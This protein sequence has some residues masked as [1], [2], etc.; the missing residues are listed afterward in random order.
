[1]T[2]EETPLFFL[3]DDE[4]LC[5]SCLVDEGLRK[6]FLSDRVEKQQEAL[7]DYCSKTCTTVATADLQSYI[8]KFFDL[9]QIE[10]VSPRADGEFWVPGLEPDEW[11]Q[12]N[13]WGCVGDELFERLCGEVVDQLYCKRDWQLPTEEERWV[14]SWEEFCQ[15]IRLRDQEFHIA[16][17]DFPGLSVPGDTSSFESSPYELYLLLLLALLKA[18]AFTPLPRHS[19]FFRARPERSSCVFNDLTSAPSSKARANR[20]SIKGESMFYGSTRLET[21]CSEIGVKTKGQEFSWGKFETTQDLILLDLVG[22]QFP[23]GR[24]D[25]DWVEDYHILAFLRHFQQDISKPINVAEQAREYWPTQAICRFIKGRAA[26][27]ILDRYQNLPLSEVRPFF[28]ELMQANHQIAGIS[29]KSSVDGGKCI[30][31]FCDHE[32]SKRW[33]SL[34]DSN[35]DVFSKDRRTPMT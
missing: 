31:L 15:R 23:T 10:Q 13:L 3:I 28:V 9:V 6:W 5:L 8:L 21:A 11:L 20:F 34:K 16:V 14:G 33:L 17:P 25:P 26:T 4:N 29:F 12:D 2:F 18:N 1:M 27:G 24:F 30:V 35:N 22:L 32:G 19:E 7:C